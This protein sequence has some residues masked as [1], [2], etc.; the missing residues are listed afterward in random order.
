MPRPFGVWAPATTLAEYRAR[1]PSFR[2]FSLR[3]VWG[4]RREVYYHPEA[5]AH[6]KDHQQYKDAVDT[7]R[8]MQVSDKF[9][10]E[11]TKLPRHPILKLMV[12][13]GL[14]ASVVYAGLR[15]YYGVYVPA[16]NPTWRKVVN[17]EWEEAI[18]NSPWDHMS[19]VWQYSDQYASVIGEAGSP[20]PR[21]FYI[22]A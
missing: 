16:N 14:Y 6:F 21:K 12:S 17:K 13:F 9:F 10:G 15:Y 18:N 20:G 3:W 19:H 4:G 22:P 2:A 1:L 5:L 8:A 7:V 11:G